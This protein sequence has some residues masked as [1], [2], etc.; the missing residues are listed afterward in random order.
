MTIQA[1]LTSGIGAALGVGLTFAA[2]ELIM[3]LRPQFLITIE[4]AMVAR[5]LAWRWP[6]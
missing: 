6:C 2:A 3:E 4:P 1:L 5:A